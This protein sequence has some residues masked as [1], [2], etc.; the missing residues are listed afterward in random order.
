MH[1][2]R[3]GRADA[4]L[5]GAARRAAA[6]VALVGGAVA[7]VVEPVADL[8]GRA[9]CRRT[10]GDRARRCTGWCR[11][12]TRPAAGAAGAAAAG[13]AL[14]GRRRR[15]RCRGRRRPLALGRMCP[16]SR[17]RRRCS[18]RSPE[19]TRP[20]SVPHCDAAAGV[21]VVDGPSQSLSRPSQI[22]ASARTP[23]SQASVPSE[24]VVCAGGALAGTQ[25]RTGA[26]SA[27]VAVV[28]GTVAVVVEA[29]AGLRHRAGTAWCRRS[30]RRCTRERRRCTRRPPRRRTPM[31]PPGLPF[32]DGA[33][34]VVV[35]AVADLGRADVACARD[36]AR[37]CTGVAR[38]AHAAA[39]RRTCRRRPDCR[40]RPRRRSRCPCRR[41]SRST[42]PTRRLQS[43]RARSRTC[44]APMGTRRRAAR[45]APPPGLPSSMA[46][47]V[48]VLIVADLGHWSPASFWLQQIAAAG[49][50]RRARRRTRRLAGGA[51]AAARVAVVDRA[52]AVVVQAVADLGRGSDV[53]VAD[54]RLR[55]R[56]AV[57]PG[58]H[59]PCSGAAPRRRPGCR[60]RR[61][62]RSRC[63]GRRRS[64][65]WGCT[66]WLQAIAPPVHAV[67]PAVHTPACRC[68]TACRRRGCPRRR[69]RCS[70]CRCRRRSRPRAATFWLQAIAPP[71]HAVVPAEQ[72]PSLPVLQRRRRRGCRCR[73]RRC[74]R[75]RGRRR[76]R[77]R[78]ARSG[79]S[80]PR[81]AVHAV[82]P[83]EH[84]PSLP[85]RAG[86]PAARVAVVDRRRRSR[87]RARRRLSAAG[88]T[89]W[90]RRSLPAVQPSCPRR[91][92]RG[93]RCCR[94]RRRR[95]CRC[96]RRRCSRCRARRRSRADGLHVLVAD[97]RA[98]GARRRARGAHARCRCSG[99]AAGV[100]VVDRRRRSRCRGR[101]RS[102]RWAARSGCRRSRRRCTRWC[103]RRT[104]PVCRCRR[105][106]AA[107]VAVVDH[108]VAVVV[109][110]VADLGRGLHVLQYRP[111]PPVH[112]VVPAR[113]R[114]A[115]RC[116]SGAAA[117]IAV[118]D[119]PSQSLSRPSQVSAE[120]DPGVQ[121]RGIPAT[122]L[123][124]D[125]WQEPTRRWS[126]RRP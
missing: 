18:C 40:R 36:H 44:V 47:A 86:D 72:A 112:A 82:V 52:V 51:P 28:D 87:C 11:P 102:R 81:P 31:P 64:R 58:P 8:G 73:R 10:A 1:C 70:C 20:A 39:R 59:T 43:E 84:T 5:S 2:V 7:V 55:P 124:T 30:C 76:S 83:A 116:C 35:E 38:A 45:A 95:G 80:R 105:Q 14:V 122:Q 17:S 108:A 56:T 104:R 4:R 57:V 69:R 22:S 74:S 21:A 77:R 85:V 97:D 106:A 121:V 78:A 9:R 15:S 115:C 114:R 42:G 16:R 123:D 101:R 48:V 120:G 60:C 100:A 62:H 34:A 91:R 33:V 103:P 3:A 75:C 12:R 61:R 113:K 99:A 96:R 37:R 71:V 119:A 24:H 26:P 68:C 19:C 90:C 6:G 79:C 89:F 66:F 54:D 107:G 67:V 94:R 98:A 46:V 23:P 88:L 110:A 53:P 49:A 29:V 118:V 41:R 13:I 117:R 93:C 65:R 50:R 63:R 32:V 126:C 27:R 25:C 92:R 111:A 125:T 109:E